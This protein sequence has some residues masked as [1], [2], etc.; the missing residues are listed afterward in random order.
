MNQNRLLIFIK[1]IYDTMDLFSD[2][3]M[4]AFEEI[5]YPCMILDA[6]QMDESLCELSKYLGVSCVKP[7][8]GVDL[9]Q[10]AAVITF[11]NMGYNLC[12]DKGFNI[13][14]QYQI[15]YYDIQMDHPFHY[16]DKIKVLPQTTRL[17]CIDR[18]HVKYVKRFFGN[19]TWVD[20]LPHGGT[21]IDESQLVPPPLSGRPIDVLYAGSLSKY[22]IEMLIPDFDQFRDFDAGELCHQ[23][24]QEVVRHPNRTTEDVLEDYFAELELPISEEQLADY[25]SRFRFLDAYAVSFFREQAVR[26]LVENGIR[27]VVYGEGWE[28]TDWADNSN[29]ILGGK[30]LAPE[31]LP[32]M[33]QSKI[34]LNTM[35]WFKDGSH[36]RVFNGML[37]GAVVVSDAS[38]YMQEQFENHKELELFELET[39]Q[40]LP[41]IVEDLLQDL[42][43]A[44][45]IA[46]AGRKK[47]MKEHTWEQRAQKITRTFGE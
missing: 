5:G 41:F 20:F 1:G 17:Y 34:V 8:D 25:I 38:V 45:Q 13:W 32:L 35:T 47:A 14:E 40:E 28:R 46:D 3:L 26:I 12:E 33:Y 30:V 2:E 18:N 24:L 19:I 36:D 22:R 6:E 10:A 29:L 31:V 21:M 39:I 43:R 23:V 37:S 16:A 42:P 44:Q 9:S 15:P 7:E 4:Q 11:N 27:V